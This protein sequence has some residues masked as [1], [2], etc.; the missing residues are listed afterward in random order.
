MNL[1]VKVREGLVTAAVG[2][3]YAGSIYAMALAVYYSITGEI[4]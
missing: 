3:I 1:I 4:P 2:F